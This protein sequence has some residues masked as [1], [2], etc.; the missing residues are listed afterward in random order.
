MQIKGINLEKKLC[1]VIY[2]N[3]IYYYIWLVNKEMNKK[4]WKKLIYLN[5]ATSQNSWY[6]QC[7]PVCEANSVEFSC[8][9]NV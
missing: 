5:F 1:N 9:L 7:L 6:K 8:Q 3:E 2:K 4:T